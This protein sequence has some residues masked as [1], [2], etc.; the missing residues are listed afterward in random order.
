MLNKPEIL[1]IDD[2]YAYR[3]FLAEGLTDAGYRVT[4]TGDTAKAFRILREKKILVALLAKN[5]SSDDTLDV[6]REIKNE[7]AYVN[8]IILAR[9]ADMKSAF[10]ALR[11]GAFDFL[12]RTPNIEEFVCAIDSAYGKA[13]KDVGKDRKSAAALKKA[14][15]ASPIIGDTPQ[16]KSIL[17]LIE[18]ISRTDAS[19]LILGETGTGKELV[20]QTIHRNSSRTNG[21]FI[22]VNCGAI[23]DNL[24]E[25]E[26]FGHE[27]GAFTDAVSCKKGLLEEADNGTVFLDEIAEISPVMQVKLLRA[28]ETGKFRR[29]GSN[30]EIQVNTR[31]ISATN[32]NLFEE[33]KKG[34]FRADLYY[35]LAIVTLDILPLRERKNDIPLLVEYFLNNLKGKMRN[36]TG[37]A[38][39]VLNIKKI[40]PS[41]MEFLME[42]DWPGNIRELKNI[43]E[44][45][46]IFSD[47]DIISPRELVQ[48]LP[49]LCTGEQMIK[50][51]SREAVPSLAEM[52]KKHIKNIIKL[53][54]G[55]IG[56]ASEALGISTRSLYGKL[57]R[58]RIDRNKVKIKT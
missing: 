50:E 34:K 13:K 18:K 17:N 27:K 39:T 28:V 29:L 15:F 47:G 5:D 30:S 16:V 46:I 24:L 8:V 14:D 22:T 6:L 12:T 42:Y 23:P 37:I 19:A 20:S 54:G 1:I 2:D 10:Q 56:R 38:G 32:K 49:G 11:L 55:N 3:V 45:L 53:T 41:A 43:V 52:E 4:E 26:I 51:I 36:K 7:F 33:V 57:K 35:R 25:S 9:R 21:P 58:H 48:V 31:I 40:S 44:R